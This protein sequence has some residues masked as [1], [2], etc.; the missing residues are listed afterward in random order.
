M[1]IPPS[2]PQHKPSLVRFY[3]DYSIADFSFSAFFTALATYGAFLGPARVG[4]CEELS[5]H[6]D[7]MRN[8]TEI[9]LNLENCELWL[10][11]AVFVGLAVMFFIMVI[12]VSVL[13][14]SVL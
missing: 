9:G 8:L 6:P 13:S 14:S 11:R 2:Q 3:R 7:L 12:R 1:L 5:R 4:I 10:S